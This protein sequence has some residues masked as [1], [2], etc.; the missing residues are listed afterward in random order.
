MHGAGYPC[1][2]KEEDYTLGVEKWQQ[3]YDE[4]K[5]PVP[6]ITPGKN[7]TLHT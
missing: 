6:I 3:W 7:I 5:V 2:A 1:G 4:A